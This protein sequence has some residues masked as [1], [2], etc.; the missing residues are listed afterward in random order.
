MNCGCCCLKTLDLCDTDICD[1]GLD[2]NV[3]A[4]S[5]GEHKFITYF[6]GMRI[7]VK[8]SFNFGDRIIFPIGDLNENY[9]YIAEA[10]DPGGN[11]ILIRKNSVQYNCFKFKTVLTKSYG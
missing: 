3:Y 10:Y 5:P 9:Q 11:R 2:L 8:E 4:Q 7:E 6:A 1:G